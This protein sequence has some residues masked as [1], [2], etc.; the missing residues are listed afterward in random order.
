[1]SYWSKVFSEKLANPTIF[2]L[3]HALVGYEN[4]PGLLESCIAL[5]LTFASKCKSSLLTHTECKTCQLDDKQE[6]EDCE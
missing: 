2:I 6:E 4:E 5:K 3:F 1:M